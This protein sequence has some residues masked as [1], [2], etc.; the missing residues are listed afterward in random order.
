MNTLVLATFTLALTGAAAVAECQFFTLI[1][2]GR[3]L[4]RSQNHPHSQHAERNGGTH[5]TS[6][7]NVD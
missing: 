5:D 7:E 3:G 2:E 4:H 6:G 1:A